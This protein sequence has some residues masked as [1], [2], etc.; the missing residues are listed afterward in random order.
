MIQLNHKSF[1]QGD[2]I[3]ILHGLFGTLDN[4]QTLAK[5]L[6][7]DYY[8]FLIDQ[9]N[10]GR[11]PHVEGMSYP[12]MAS[13]LK[14]FLEQNWI[15]QAH[16]IGHSMGGKTA[17]Q[18]ALEYPDIVDKL[19]VV[20][21]APKT[22]LGGHELIL[23]ALRNFPV[24]SVESRKEAEQTLLEAGIEE[25]GIR[26]FLLKNLTRSKAG[27]YEWKMNFPEIDKHYQNILA[28]IETANKSAFDGET[29]FVRGANSN[30]IQDKDINTI[31]QFFP[32]SKLETVPQAGHWVHAEQPQALLELLRTFL[33]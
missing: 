27:G 29:L 22:Y 18:F 20:D 8:V 26:Q 23:S 12:L 28:N 21:I 24:N 31:N 2:A 25:L 11:S 32:Q 14:D 30:Y 13:D 17:M 7:E 15:H 33:N 10:H 4:W 16:I 3:V 9:R 6:A 1:G 5:K 19:V